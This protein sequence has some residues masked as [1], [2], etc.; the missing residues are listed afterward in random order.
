MNTLYL[1]QRIPYP[2]N[3][4]EKIRTFNQIKYLLERGHKVHVYAPIESPEE[5]DFAKDFQLH[6]GLDVYCSRLSSK[7]GRYASAIVGNKAISV[8]HFYSSRLQSEID[9][10]LST[11]TID[12]LVCTSSSMAE[13]VFNSRVMKHLDQKPVL[14]MDFMDLD[15]DKWLQY[16]DFSP[17][18][19]KWI[20]GR[21]F[22]RLADYEIK[23]N[24]YFDYS[25]FVSQR[26]VD[27][28][29]QSS[30][31][32][33]MPLVIGNGIDTE[34][35]MPSTQRADLSRPVLLFTGVM[36]YKPNVD[37]VIWFCREIWPEVCQRHADAEFIIAGMKPTQEV[38]ALES[39]EGVTVTGFVDDI[40]PYYHRANIFV[41]PLRIAR[42]LQNKVLQA[43]A[44]GLPVISTAMGANGINCEDGKHLLIADDPSTFLNHIDGL[45][46]K[47]E[48]YETIRNNALDLVDAEYSW[49]R[50]L[51]KFASILSPGEIS[52]D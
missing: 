44:C 2:P 37:G 10:L 27:Q 3:K 12:C 21:E 28:F 38:K 40:L 7:I 14:I 33:K 39:L 6:H 34:Y 11:R 5:L 29:C 13:Y 8:S 36:D 31:H 22:R 45:I 9:E 30:R 17:P 32:Q 1:C 41:A 19:M 16:Q 20:Y 49:D 23:I 51:Q 24:R 52:N 47:P 4:G 25:V 15:S 46:S 26:E 42:G 35:F 18:P 43:F 48:L 50:V